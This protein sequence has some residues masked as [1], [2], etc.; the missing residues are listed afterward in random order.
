MCASR[1]NPKWPGVINGHWWERQHILSEEC[2]IEVRRWRQI[3][4]SAHR[5]N[6]LWLSVQRW[7]LIP[8]LKTITETIRCV[9]DVI[10]Y[11]MFSLCGLI[12]SGQELVHQSPLTGR[13]VPYV[14]SPYLCARFSLAEYPKR[15]A[16]EW[17]TFRY[18]KP[19]S[20]RPTNQNHRD[21]NSRT[22]LRYCSQSLPLRSP[23]QPSSSSAIFTSPIRTAMK[24]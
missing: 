2:P 7:W 8:E 22:L 1:S 9:R 19:G 4:D 3:S 23:F 13:Y 11:W 10:A 18:R 6:F 24:T 5:L 16:L 21:V 15:G 17:N 14:T 20:T 12:R